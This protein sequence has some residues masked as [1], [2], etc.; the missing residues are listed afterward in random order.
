MNLVKRKPAYI[1]FWVALSLLIFNSCVDEQK[2]PIPNTI[3][4][5]YKKLEDLLNFHTI[6]I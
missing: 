2:A 5:E 6:P 4:A 1:T 3:S